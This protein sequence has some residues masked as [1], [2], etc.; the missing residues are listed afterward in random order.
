LIVNKNTDAELRLLEN[1]T[2]AHQ[3]RR[4][5]A[6]IDVVAGDRTGLRK[7]YTYIKP[8]IPPTTA[9]FGA[10][11]NV[12]S[13]RELIVLCWQYCFYSHPLIKISSLR[14]MAL[15]FLRQCSFSNISVPGWR[16]F[17]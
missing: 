3:D 5:F 12:R 15:N 7:F 10:D 11:G 9:W 2:S 17:M 1:H 4:R 8:K 13:T 14:T 16:W 6:L